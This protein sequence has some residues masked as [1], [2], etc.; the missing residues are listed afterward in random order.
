ML[1]HAMGA[2]SGFSV[3][4]TLLG[5]RDSFLPPTINFSERDPELPDIDPVPNKARR[6]TVEIA[7]VHGFAFGG[8]N[9]IT[10]FGQVS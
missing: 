5:M 7:Q 4:A 10:I 8:N 1:G 6:Q 2:A 3:I 9:A